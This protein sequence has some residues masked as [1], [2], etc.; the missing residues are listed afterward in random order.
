MTVDLL[1]SDKPNCVVIDF[2]VSA[3]PWTSWMM[4]LLLTRYAGHGSGDFCLVFQALPSLYG[5]RYRYMQE[6]HVH[7]GTEEVLC[8]LVQDQWRLYLRRW[9]EFSR[10]FIP[11]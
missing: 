2:T 8:P 11:A 4:S 9:N 1:I 10:K 7:A 3:L 5:E 6:A